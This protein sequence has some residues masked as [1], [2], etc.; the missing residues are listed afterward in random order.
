MNYT[1]ITDLPALEAF[2]AWLPELLPH[3]KYYLCLFARKKYC[4]TVGYIKTDKSQMKRFLADKERMIEKIRQL[5]CPLGSYMQHGNPI[6]QEA[7][8]LYITTNPRDLWKANF[9]AIGDLGKIIQ[10]QGKTSNPH[11]EVMSSIQRARGTKHYVDFDIDNK[12]PGTLERIQAALPGEQLNKSYFILE[13]RGGYH[14]LVNP[15]LLTVSYV[16]GAAHWH[17]ELSKM[18]DVTGDKMIPVP[19]TH[20]GGFTPRF[21]TAA[22]SMADAY[23]ATLGGVMAIAPDAYGAALEKI[24]QLMGRVNDDAFQAEVAEH[25]KSLPSYMD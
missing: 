16:K 10:C 2:V 3:E 17:Q 14:V 23:E 18:S 12:A 11:Q 24:S 8:A 19:G 13:T 5:E 6:P 25:G 20:Q 1:I 15:K 9:D 21:L 7:L 22:M 4:S